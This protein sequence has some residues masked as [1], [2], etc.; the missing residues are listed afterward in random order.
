MKEL[1]GYGTDD[2]LPDYRSLPAAPQGHFA[3]PYG[4]GYTS[5]MIPVVALP[6]KLRETVASGVHFRQPMAELEALAGNSGNGTVLFNWPG[7]WIAWIQAEGKF[8]PDFA[9]YAAWQ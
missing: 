5:V 4:S 6:D 1:N 2:P 3:G 9:L 8:D 7:N